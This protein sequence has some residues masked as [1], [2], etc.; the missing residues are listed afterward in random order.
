MNL[1]RWVVR[2]LLTATATVA[3]AIAVAALRETGGLSPAAWAATA[4]AM[5]VLAAVISAWTSRRVFELQED[6]FQPNPQFSIDSTESL[7]LH[8]PWLHHLFGTAHV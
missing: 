3:C 7:F 8:G 2:A 6:A 5:A 1:E 4:A